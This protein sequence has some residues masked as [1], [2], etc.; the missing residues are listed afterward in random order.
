MTPAEFEALP[1]FPLRG[2]EGNDPTGYTALQSALLGY[3]DYY[4]T[5]LWLVFFGSLFYMVLRYLRP[6]IFSPE[7]A[8]AAPVPAPVIEGDWKQRAIARYKRIFHISEI[9]N[10]LT[11]RLFGGAILLGF[12]VTF[13][14]W[15]SSTANSLSALNT[16]SYI[17]W[18][19]FQ[20]CAKW[21]LFDSRPNGYT[22]NTI[23]MAMFGLIFLAVYGL[24]A[25]KYVIAH[26]CI[27]VLFAF[28]IYVTLIN[29]S[30]NANYDY[31]HTAFCLVFLFAAHKRFFGSLTVIF[32]YFLSTAA[33][34]HETWTLGTYFTALQ[35][36]LPLFPKGTT[37]LWT[38]LVILME[39]VGAWFLLSKNKY[40][41]RPAVFFF[42]CFHLYSGILVGYHYPSIV[43][44]SLLIFFGPLYKPFER[45]P[46]DLSALRGWF[47]IGALL[48]LQMISHFIPGDEKLTMEGNFYG[49]YMFEANHQCLV[50]VKNEVG[51][52]IYN[53]AS[54]NARYRCDPYRIMFQTQNIFCKQEHK[55]Q[56]NLQIGHSING[57]PFYLIVDEADL[58]SLTYTP[59]GRNHWIKTE[60]TARP[61][62]RPH[63]N[64]YW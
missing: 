58:C 37:M 31:Y 27:L 53:Q 24:L 61:M 15:E 48:C 43:M 35:T 34:I 51:S 36:D 18:P 10:D 7:K 33:K 20:D 13:R 49:L 19:F 30:Y 21:I 1:L 56:L 17:C 14:G 59:F 44:P 63:K 42:A 6:A 54:T 57:G 60:E 22:L 3:I 4:H 29:F 41:Q 8:A 50:R 40:L 12:M 16:N 39:M 64:L 2:T 28:K 25:K 26:A 38:N 5:A 11:L 55:P 62:A 9:E 32:L 52:D 45:V 46:V 23:F 47:L